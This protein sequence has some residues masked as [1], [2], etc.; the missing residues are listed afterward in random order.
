MPTKLYDLWPEL[1]GKH[2][3]VVAPWGT[4]EG[5]LIGITAP[6]DA[7]A[8]HPEAELPWAIR[9]D[10]GQE[11]LLDP[12]NP[13]IK[14]YVEGQQLGASGTIPLTTGL[15]DRVHDLLTKY[16]HFLAML[17]KASSRNRR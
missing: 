13:A 9:T 10:D 5:T 14:I 2:L 7:S 4:L 16:D 8:V 6:A 3:K 1:E 11:V 15:Q 17:R 12:E